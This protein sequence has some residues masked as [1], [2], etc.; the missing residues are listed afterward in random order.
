MIAEDKRLEILIEKE[1]NYLRCVF[2]GQGIYE[3]AK[4]ASLRLSQQFPAP[5][6]LVPA[7]EREIRTGRIR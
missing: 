2:L 6:S 3:M 1:I 5:F 7:S 4:M